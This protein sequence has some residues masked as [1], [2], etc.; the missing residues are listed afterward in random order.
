MTTTLHHDE[1]GW[2]DYINTNGH[3]ARWQLLRDRQIQMPMLYHS[4]TR[5]ASLD[6]NTNV[7]SQQR[8][9]DIIPPASDTCII[10]LKELC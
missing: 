6:T 3:V 7:I 9:P 2:F 10:V 4:N 8:E 1:E 5:Q